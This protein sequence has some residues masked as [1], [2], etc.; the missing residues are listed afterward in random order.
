MTDKL[1]IAKIDALDHNFARMKQEADGAY[2]FARV[3]LGDRHLITLG[4]QLL[5]N[6][7]TDLAAM[8]R[9]EVQRMREGIRQ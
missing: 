4:A 1:T 3:L 2:N 9:D 5:S 7:A 6:Q 8:V